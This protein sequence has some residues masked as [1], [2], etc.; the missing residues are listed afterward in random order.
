[1]PSL[2]R[3]E[4]Y[5]SIDHRFSPGVTADVARANGFDPR[6]L[7]SG[8]HMECATLFCK[9]CGGTW[10]KNVFRSRERA[11]CAKCDH[12]ICDVCDSKRHAADYVHF[13]VDTLKD[14]VQ[15][16]GMELGSPLGLITA[17]KIYIP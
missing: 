17:P 5:L 13:N 8:Q 15:E 9:H 3:F 6:Q 7:A 11:Y 1:M 16:K 12:Y 14:M 2:K 4:G 10:A